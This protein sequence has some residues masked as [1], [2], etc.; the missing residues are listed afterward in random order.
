RL[1]AQNIL[2][3]YQLRDQ[4]ELDLPLS[5][6]A[7][8]V[9]DLID[10]GGQKDGPFRINDIRAGAVLKISARVQYPKRFLSFRADQITLAAAAPQISSVPAIVAAQL[11]G[12]GGDREATNLVIGAFARPWPGE[13]TINDDI[14]GALTARMKSS[15]IIGE[16]TKT[17]PPASS[18]LWDKANRIEL[19]LYDGHLSS[20]SELET[21]NG[22]NRIAVLADDGVWEVIGFEQAQLISQNSYRLSLLLRGLNNSSP[23]A[24][25]A[26]AVGNPVVVLS[27]ALV[28]IAVKNDQLDTSLALR[29]YAGSS[30][31]VGQPFSVQLS[32]G[33]AIPLAPAHLKAALVSGSNDISIGW[34]RRSRIGGNDWGGV[35]IALDFT[36]ESYLVSIFNGS[37]IVR[38]LESTTPF[39]T[40]SQADQNADFGASPPAFDFLVQQVSAVYG[41]GHGTFGTFVA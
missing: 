2:D 21:L 24:P 10:I 29:A 38:Q 27:S 16:L 1:A 5:Y 18:C 19:S 20:A 26:S 25:A 40:Y 41:P 15:A 7:L 34:T 28:S 31:L 17:L 4:L 23:P 32:R 35:E 9:G 12:G 37:A 30:D 6:R 3:Q 36:P 8:E 14:S 11:P 39:V 33:P 22:A 13:V